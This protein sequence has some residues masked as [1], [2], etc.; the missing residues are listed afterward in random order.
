[1]LQQLGLVQLN[2]QPAQQM[3]RSEN[4]NQFASQECVVVIV[5][6]FGINNVCLSVCPSHLSFMIAADLPPLTN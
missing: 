5:S 6:Q 4:K 2:E 1:M 3:S